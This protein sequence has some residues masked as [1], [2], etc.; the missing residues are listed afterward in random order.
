MG[1]PDIDICKCC[2]EHC[3][4]IETDEGEWESDCCGAGPINT[5][6]DDYDRE[7]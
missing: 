1:A 6:G 4:F 7:R 5:D 3:D 2:G